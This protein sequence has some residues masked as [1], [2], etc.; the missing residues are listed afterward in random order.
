MNLQFTIKKAA[1][2]YCSKGGFTLIELLVVIAVLSVLSVALLS[3]I[4]PI[5]QINKGNDTAKKSD[6]AE[7]LN[8]NERY[9]TTFSTYPWD[10]TKIGV[11]LNKKQASDTAGAGI[12]ELVAKNEMKSQFK[13]RQNLDTLYITQDASSNLVSVCFAPTST[14][15][16]AQA[17]KNQDGSSG[18]TTGTCYICVPE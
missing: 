16:K 6:S 5:E 11:T 14:T 1:R 10:P 3:A 8:A 2:N 12:D 18:C 7:L 15:F 4:N 13:T 9:Y 17:S